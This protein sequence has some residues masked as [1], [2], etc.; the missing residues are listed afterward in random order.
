MARTPR[1]VPKI[2]SGALSHP[3]AEREATTVIKSPP[4]II[5]A[6]VRHASCV[7]SEEPSSG[8]LS[9]SP[10]TGVVEDLV[11]RLIREMIE[12]WRGGSCPPV[13][14]FLAR[15][16]TLLD[17]ADAATRLIS[18]E[19][20]LRRE[21]GIAVSTDQYVSR[22]PQWEERLVE[23]IDQST[24]VTCVV[25][26]PS[27]P[28]AGDSIGEF[29]L[30]TVLGRGVRGSVFLAVQPSLADRP[31]V[32]KLTPRDGREHLSLARL[33]HANIVP[34]FWVQDLPE[35]DL[36]VMCM[37][38]LGGTTLAQ[39][40]NMLGEVP[41]ARRTGRDLLDAIDQVQANAPLAV[42]VQGPARQ[43]LARASY[44][45]AVCW[46]GTCLAEALQFA[47]QRE[48]LHLD[49]KPSN[50]LLAAD[51][52]P[53]LLD[54]HLAQA[55][56]RPDGRALQRLGGT[57]AYMSPEQWA[58][59]VE[60]RSGRA[61]ALPVDGRSDIYA[62]GILLY[63][64]LGGTMEVGAWLP[65]RQIVRLEPQI[66]VGLVDII[67]RCLAYD[68]RDRYPD[69]SLLAEDLRRH[70][71]DLPLRG[72]ANRSLRERWR[73][74]RRRRPHALGWAAF[75]T[76]ALAA[77]L[78][79]GLVAW[80]DARQR[81]L[82]AEA[83]L[84]EGRKHL[85]ERA[86]ATAV[87]VL[88][89]GLALTDRS[90]IPAFDL[91]LSQ[92]R[93]LRR[94][95]GEEL[96][97]AQRAEMAK[98]LHDLVER[99]RLLY[100]TDFPPTAALRTLEERLRATWD[101][102]GRIVAQ[103]GGGLGLEFER[104]LRTDLLDLGILWAD[105]RVRL[106]SGARGRLGA[107]GGPP[108]LGSGRRAVRCEPGPRARAPVPRRGPRPVGRGT[109]GRAT[110][111]RARPEHRLGTL[112]LRSRP[113]QRRRLGGRRPRVRRRY[114]PPTPGSLGPFLPRDLLLSP[115]TF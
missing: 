8:S 33:Q 15:H 85:D 106:A 71:T 112:C 12:A 32:L 90:R 95:L 104:R 86:Y 6:V 7:A 57:P 26:P 11:T 79:L 20:R 27:F 5:P 91:S 96:H 93:Q 4:G 53:M 50:V 82:R 46:I 111:R 114:G 74:W 73:K 72:V 54:F 55:P 49:L 44:V 101:A 35:R 28:V 68:A 88:E 98:E 30:L 80:S 10:G 81:L 18:E 56:I 39:L 105:L 45:Q 110:T 69:A 48:L 13:E 94:T 41:I 19:I 77:A 108:D 109:R 84:A 40:I 107:S 60:A 22:F 70:L 43:F 29:Q 25:S 58:A 63:E 31:V 14:E 61:V 64:A 42:P 103:L 51:G 62:L 16:P 52:T 115:P 2:P 3:D 65:T 66:P 92:A 102:R 23:L 99:V 38:Y 59:M 34:L 97:R 24:C 67:S 9:E 37:P 100:G 47:H 78:A 21:M 1:G 83:A 87:S 113:P 89:R 36:R 17:H 75:T 76:L